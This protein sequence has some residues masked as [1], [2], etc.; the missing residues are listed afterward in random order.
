MLLI[1]T[2][3]YEDPMII[4]LQQIM[5]PILDSFRQSLSSTYLQHRLVEAKVSCFAHIVLRLYEF[6]SDK[7]RACLR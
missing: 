5:E 7:L 3:K 2:T 1:L 4:W 6:G